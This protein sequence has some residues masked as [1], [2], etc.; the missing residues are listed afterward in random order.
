MAEADPVIRCDICDN[1]YDSQC[2]GVPYDTFMILVSTVRDCGWVC[3]ECRRIQKTVVNCLT[4][5]LATI[6]ETVADMKRIIDQ[7]KRH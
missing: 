7:L 2:A 3:F 6:N 5:S 4:T 1:D